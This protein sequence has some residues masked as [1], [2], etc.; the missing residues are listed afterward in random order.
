MT[1]SHLKVTCDDIGKK[2]KDF[3]GDLLAES[4][5]QA[6]VDHLDDCPKCTS[7]VRGMGSFSNQLWELGDIEVPSDLDSTILFSIQKS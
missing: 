3:V 2:L 7:Y 1:G 6:F 4:D 5:Y